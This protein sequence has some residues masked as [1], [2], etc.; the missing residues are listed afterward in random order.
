MITKTRIQDVLNPVQGL[1]IK[2]VEYNKNI[3]K[4]NVSNLQSYQ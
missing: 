1:D 2:F 3:L 4:L